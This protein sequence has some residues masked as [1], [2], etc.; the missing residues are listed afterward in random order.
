MKFS[1]FKQNRKQS[2]IL[3]SK[4]AA[5]YH[6]VSRTAFNDFKFTDK[7]KQVLLGILERQAAFC[8]IEVLTYCLLDNHFHLLVRVPYTQEKL[9]DSEIIRRYEALYE[10]RPVPANALTVDELKSTLSAGGA[11]ARKVRNQLLARME[12]L[13]VFVKEMKHRFC[14]WYNKNNE[15]H[16]TIWCEKFKSTLIEDIP[17]A[18]RLVAAYID[19]NAV[20]ANICD[21]PAA[22][23]FCGYAQAIQGNSKARIGLQNVMSKRDWSNARKKYTQLLQEDQ[24]VQTDAFLSPAS[25]R[26]MLSNHQHIPLGK[27]LRSRISALSKGGVIGSREYVEAWRKWREKRFGFK[28]S[29]QPKSLPEE[30]LNWAYVLSPIIRGSGYRKLT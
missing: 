10:N 21:D 8:G 28:K 18:V 29:S 5:V 17:G 22:Y 25:A 11:K 2:R 9:K 27:L 13:S 24:P 3:V 1:L 4:E 16:G 7:H 19:L 6:V 30:S 15:N 23:H 14:I 20:R 12:N 26:E